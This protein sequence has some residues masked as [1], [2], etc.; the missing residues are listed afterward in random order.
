MSPAQLR[1]YV[2]ELK[3]AGLMSCQVRV[4]TP[5][6]QLELALVFGPDPVD[7]GPLSAPTPGGWKGPERLDANFEDE[8]PQLVPPAR[9]EV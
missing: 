2:D 5:E 1:E 8:L 9:P 7:G 6:G 4:P 3:T